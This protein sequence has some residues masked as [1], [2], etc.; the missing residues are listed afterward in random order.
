MR[1][2]LISALVLLVAAV[3]YFLYVPH[4]KDAA[5]VPTK[6]A[7]SSAIVFVHDSY[8]K[9]VHTLRG[10]VQIPTPCT[11]IAAQ[12]SVSGASTSPNIAIAVLLNPDDGICLQ[13]LATSTF[14]LTASAPKTVTITATVN[15]E[16]ATVV[17]N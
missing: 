14:T 8:S 5:V 1:T 12:T 15:G 7:S 10:A 2:I 11:T 3:V 6:S 17:A 4:T 16:D 13:V 9:G